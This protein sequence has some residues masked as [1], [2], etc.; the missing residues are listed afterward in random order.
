MPTDKPRFTISMDDDLY[1]QVNDFRFSRKIRSQ[2]KTIVELVRKGIEVENM[3]TEK[4]RVTITMTEEQLGQIE[5]YK[6]SNKMK[7]QTQAILSLIERGI[8]ALEAQ[9]VKALKKASEAEL[10]APKANEKAHIQMFADVLAKAGMLDDNGDLSDSDLEFLQAM[11]LA[12]KAHFKER[13]K[14]RD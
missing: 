2:S 4:P 6:F 11:L 8:D 14:R 3:P 5:S 7:N 12:L 9:D 1:N 10:P 13:K